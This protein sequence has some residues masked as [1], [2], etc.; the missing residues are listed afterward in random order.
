MKTPG[1]KTPEIL[2]P[3]WEKMDQENLGPVPFE[4]LANLE[5]LKIR[6]MTGGLPK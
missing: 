3:R 6:T 1:E 4:N 2:A 5:V